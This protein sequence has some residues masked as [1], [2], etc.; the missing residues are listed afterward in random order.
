MGFTEYLRLG[1]RIQIQ[2]AFIVFPQRVK[3]SKQPGFNEMH[4]KIK[5]PLTGQVR[6]YPFIAF[7]FRNNI[8]DTAPIRNIR[9]GIDQQHT[10]II[11]TCLLMRVKTIVCFL[12]TFPRITSSV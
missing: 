6:A 8:P 5:M 7:P 11:R 2:I 4:H 3:V 12:S 10:K 1:K 9:F